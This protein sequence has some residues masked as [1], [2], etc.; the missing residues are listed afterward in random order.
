MPEIADVVPGQDVLAEW[1]NIIRN[2]V[3]SRYTTQ[4]ALEVQEPN[5]PNGSLRW[6]DDN[7]LLLRS[8]GAW[9]PVVVIPDGRGS[10]LY[11]TDGDE[12]WEVFDDVG[13]LRALGSG[14]V[15]AGNGSA[16][17]PAYSFDQDRDTGLWR[18]AANQ[19]SVEGLLLLDDAQYGSAYSSVSTGITSTPQNFLKLDLP[20][21]PTSGVWLFQ[22]G[23]VID[24]SV[25]DSGTWQFALRSGLNTEYGM[26]STHVSTWHSGAPANQGG[27]FGGSAIASIDNPAVQISLVSRSVSGGTQLVGAQFITALR[28]A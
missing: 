2:R 22:W 18:S 21:S 14:I 11:D 25:N 13:T 17:E 20:G 12:A 1:G 19:M 6:A 10:V 5:A 4:A 24:C 7:G 26:R 15:Y 23:G 8:G 16:S 28:I 27:A 3:V 9:V